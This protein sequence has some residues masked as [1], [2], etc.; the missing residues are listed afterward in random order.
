MDTVRWQVQLEQ[1]DCN[2]TLA[3]SGISLK[4]RA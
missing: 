1:L 3:L 2:G 4:D